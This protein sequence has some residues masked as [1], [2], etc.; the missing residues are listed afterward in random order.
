MEAFCESRHNRC[1]LQCRELWK[2]DFVCSG[3]K[4]NDWPPQNFPRYHKHKQAE[5]F[6]SSCWNCKW[7]RQCDW[8]RRKRYRFL[9]L[10]IGLV[11]K[12]SSETSEDNSGVLEAFARYFGKGKLQLG[13]FSHRWHSR[14]NGTMATQRNSNTTNVI[15][16]AD[17]SS[18]NCL[19]LYAVLS[20]H[21]P[22][23][24]ATSR[25]LL[26][27]PQTEEPEW[28][29]RRSMLRAFSKDIFTVISKCNALLINF[30]NK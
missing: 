16:S 10:I 3:H 17:L 28:P 12:H 6:S 9:F 24:N 7:R 11:F 1:S 18:I 15:K 23:T 20:R 29:P 4:W 19:M 26:E 25:W 13:N 30:L 22:K 8:S 2:V 14:K 27:S 5:T 21:P